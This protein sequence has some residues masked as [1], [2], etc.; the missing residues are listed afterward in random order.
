[1][2]IELIISSHSI[3]VKNYSPKN[4]ISKKIKAPN[5]HVPLC[6]TKP[7][8]GDIAADDLSEYS[9]K[10]ELCKLIVTIIADQFD[11]PVDQMMC[12]TRACAKAA[13]A[14]QIA[15]YLAHT[16]FSIAYG[17]AA[18]FFN[19]DRTTIS[20]ACKMI[21]DQRDDIEFDLKIEKM[22]AQLLAATHAGNR[23]RQADQGRALYLSEDQ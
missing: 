22:E 8:S 17:H 10:N 20:H 1:M 21:E 19:R 15:I 7:I 3:S 11:I 16:V 9:Q 23:L 6:K 18:D 2:T 12:K 5:I 4:S 13:R 14:R